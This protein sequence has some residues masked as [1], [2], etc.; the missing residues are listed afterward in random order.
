MTVI[1][2][3]YRQE[4]HQ[5]QLFLQLHSFIM[6]YGH[7]IQSSIKYK[8][9]FYSLTKSMCYISPQKKGGVEVVFWNAVKMTKS[10]PLLD[11]KKRKW[12]AGISYNH[13]DEVDFEVLDK[14]IQ[15]AVSVDGLS[16][17]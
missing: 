5:R 4:G 11:K 1:D 14:I 3:L 9:P 13:I 6:G 8:I 7:G 17:K 12:F 15:E 16:T 2:F 10:L